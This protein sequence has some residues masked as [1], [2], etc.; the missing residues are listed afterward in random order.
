MSAAANSAAITLINVDCTCGMVFA[1]P[2][3][4]IES[5]R[6]DGKVF[7]CPSGHELHYKIEPDKD[8][9]E[10]EN[11][12]K[13][14][15]WEQQE[16]KQQRERADAAERRA[17]SLRGH[18][19]RLRKRIAEGKCPYCALVFDDMATHIAEAHPRYRGAEEDT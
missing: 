16:S 5:R 11:L 2:A 12:R 6:K 1:A 4:F 13:R 3:R 8:E 19:T 18:A 15:E 14:I 7:Y 9:R 17:R 10:K